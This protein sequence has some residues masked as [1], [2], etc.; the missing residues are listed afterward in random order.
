M[1]KFKE[2]ANCVGTDPDSFF[3]EEGSATYPEVRLIREICL[4]CKAKPE[5]LEY[6]LNHD[7]KGYWANTTEGKR[8]KMRLQ[9]NII[10]RPLHLDYN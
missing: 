2:P 4:A 5:C 9:L 8:E 6:A 1:N 10:P 7:V 3:T